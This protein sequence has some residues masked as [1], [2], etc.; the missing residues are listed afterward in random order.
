MVLWSFK[1]GGGARNSC[2]KRNL[3]IFPPDLSTLLQTSPGTNGIPKKLLRPDV[4]RK[5]WDIVSTDAFPM[6][7]L[8]SEW[9]IVAMAPSI[10]ITVKYIIKS[11]AISPVH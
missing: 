4:S 6:G 11:P 3:S 2:R 1:R 7:H 9:D 8:K 10:P 5:Q